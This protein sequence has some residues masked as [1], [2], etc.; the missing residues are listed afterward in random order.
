MPAKRVRKAPTRAAKAS[1]TVHP[2]G[3]VE[4]VFQ[5]EMPGMCIVLVCVL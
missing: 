1:A 2:N 3:A 5:L 4:T